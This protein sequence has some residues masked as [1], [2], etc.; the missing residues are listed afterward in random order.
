MTLAVAPFGA[1]NITNRTLGSNSEIGRH[2]VS[3][4]ATSITVSVSII[5]IISVLLLTLGLRGSSVV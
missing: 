5:L 2:I 4:I 1:L 3:A